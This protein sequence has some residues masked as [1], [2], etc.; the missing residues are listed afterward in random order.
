MAG[1]ELRPGD[2]PSRPAGAGRRRVDEWA[3]ACGSG[4]GEQDPGP[5]SKRREPQDRSST[6]SAKPVW[7]NWRL[8][9]SARRFSSAWIRR[10]CTWRRP[11]QCPWSP[12]LAPRGRYS[13][14]PWGNGHV[15]ITSPYL[16]RPCGQDGCLGSKRSDCLEAI[17]AQTIWEAVEPVLSRV[18]GGAFP[19]HLSVARV[20]GGGDV[21]FHLSP[22]GHF[23][24]LSPPF[25]KGGAGGFC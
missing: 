14:G 19:P 8:S 23:R 4:G 10:R 24:Q 6:S 25:G 11:C 3:R 22:G 16:C 12:S 13:W 5:G 9:W 21:R 2:R 1:G 7:R 20:P 18:L 17:S 15:V